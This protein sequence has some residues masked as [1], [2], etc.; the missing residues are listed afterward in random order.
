MGTSVPWD[1]WRKLHFREAPQ[2]CIDVVRVD[3]LAD[4]CPLLIGATAHKLM[5]DE[6]RIAAGHGPRGPVETN[7]S[8]AHG[9][10]A[11]ER[12]RAWSAPAVERRISSA[13]LAG[14]LLKAIA[15]A[16]AS[17]P[18]GPGAVKAVAAAG[19]VANHLV[20]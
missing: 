11:M 9:P 5:T 12:P 19:R 13:L 17:L 15:A 10:C 4:K 7:F 20:I 6:I 14:S 18:R 3:D 8:V 1:S 16:Y 2:T